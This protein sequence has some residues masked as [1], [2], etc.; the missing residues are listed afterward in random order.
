M[1]LVEMED[2]LLLVVQEVASNGSVCYWIWWRWWCLLWSIRQGTAP[3][4]MVVPGIVVVRYQ[5]GQLTAT[6]KATGG[7]ISYYGGKTIHTFTYH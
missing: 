6:A 7:A 3:V 1:V 2:V 5:I 4:A